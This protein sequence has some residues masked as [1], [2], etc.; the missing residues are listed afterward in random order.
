MP[1]YN[2]TKVVNPAQLTIEIQES[3]IT[4]ALN[5]I[6][7]N[8][9]N[10]DIDFKADLSVSEK[11][12]LDALVANH[13]DAPTSASTLLPVQLPV[14]TI[15]REYYKYLDSTDLVSDCT[16]TNAY[17]DIVANPLKDILISKMTFTYTYKY[18]GWVKFDRWGK[19]RLTNGIRVEISTSDIDTYHI[20]VIQKFQDLVGQS[21]Y[22]YNF[23]RIDGEKNTYKVSASLVF[24][25]PIRLKK[26]TAD[27]MS[28]VLNDDFSDLIDFTIC[29]EGFKED[30]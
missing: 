17:L 11:T 30:V 2:Y 4:I 5:S 16:D 27:K 18:K 12:T 1:I 8:V 19:D 7:L 20:P 22:R 15:W 10:L 26:A 13:I 21:L 6:L 14:K 9:D 24:D 28:I 29:A 25:I 3:P 23:T